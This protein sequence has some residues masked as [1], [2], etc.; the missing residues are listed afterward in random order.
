MAEQLYQ[1]QDLINTWA[2]S[3]SDELDLVPLN[4]AR[5]TQKFSG[6]QI[7]GDSDR[8]AYYTASS[9][10]NGNDPDYA[11]D[12]STTSSWATNSGTVTGWLQVFLPWF[13]RILTSYTVQAPVAT[14]TRCPKDWTMQGSWDGVTWY[15]VDTVVG[16]I[17]WGSSEIRTFACDVAD[18]P[19]N[20]FRMVITANNGATDAVLITELTLISTQTP[21]DCELLGTSMYLGMSSEPYVG[22]P[23]NLSSISEQVQPPSGAGGNSCF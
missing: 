23:W 22:C 8:W 5:V 11:F 6:Q 4:V 9:S 18:T 13:R 7:P 15:V 2:L 10:N 3:E 17:A 19:Y 20:Y 12:G 21:P 1:L 14:M 16:S